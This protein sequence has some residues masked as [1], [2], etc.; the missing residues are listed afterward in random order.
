M[1]GWDLKSKT[2]DALM[3]AQAAPRDNRACGNVDKECANV[4]SDPDPPTSLN[5]YSIRPLSLPQDLMLHLC[6]PEDVWFLLIA[7]CDQ[8]DV[9]NRSQPIIENADLLREDLSICQV[10]DAT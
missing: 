3:M 8:A 9:V 1:T 2:S 10:P 5:I 4:S 7:R 6:L